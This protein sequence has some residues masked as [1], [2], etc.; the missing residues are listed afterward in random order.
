MTSEPSRPLGPSNPNAA[1]H[2]QAGRGRFILTLCRLA[3][4]VSI[5]PPESSHTRPFTFFTSRARQP[6]GSERLYLHMGYFET[7][8]DAEKYLEV[9]RRHYPNAFAPEAPVELLWPADSEAASFAHAPIAALVPQGGDRAQPVKEALTDTQVIRTLETRGAATDQSDADVSN[10]DHIALLRPDD[11]GTRQALREAVAEGAPVS[12]AVQLHW[13]AEPIDV[14]TVSALPVFKLHTHYATESRRQGRS[15]HFLRLGFFADPMSAKQVAV[16]VLSSY[17]TAAVVPVLEQEVTRARAAGRFPSVVPSLEEQRIDRNID[18][19]RTS[20][21][22][23]LASPLLEVPQR[24][25]RLTEPVRQPVETSPKR[26]TLKEDS[27]S[28]SESG[29]RHLRIEVQEHLSG[30]WKIVRLGAK[31]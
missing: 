23:T 13:S 10:S 20:G 5:A 28:L 2:A 26:P 16:Q 29:V 4:P 27:D 1:H 19:S 18:S 3:A 30:R 6:D 8:A 21:P 24:V 11:T 25:V 22:S 9:V 14:T 12:F 15:C 31:S 7:L 17:A